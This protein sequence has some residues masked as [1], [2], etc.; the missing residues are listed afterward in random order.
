MF[1][2][3]FFKSPIDELLTDKIP[4]DE[5]FSTLFNFFVFHNI[6][7]LCRLIKIKR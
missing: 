3:P 6:S 7:P 1:R 5:L 4:K 2:N